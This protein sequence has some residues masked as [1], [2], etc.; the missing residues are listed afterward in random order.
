MTD[1]TSQV[2][3]SKVSSLLD[4]AAATTDAAATAAVG[5]STPDLYH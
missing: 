1:E 4:S 5:A 3:E 2:S